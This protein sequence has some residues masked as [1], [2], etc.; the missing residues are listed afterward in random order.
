MKK[1]RQSNI[2]MQPYPVY[3]NYPGMVGMPAMGPNPMMPGIPA[4]GMMP[5]IPAGN[6]PMMPTVTPTTGCGCSGNGNTNQNMGNSQNQIERQLD[7]LDRRVSRLENA[8]LVDKGTP[9]INNKFTN[10]TFQM[11]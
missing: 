5:G 1:D 10:D 8:V 3:P 6:M 4:N 2:G 9:Y 11:M 7:M